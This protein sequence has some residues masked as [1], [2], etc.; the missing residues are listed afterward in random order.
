MDLDC[1]ARESD[2]A[3]LLLSLDELRALE[4]RLRQHCPAHVAAGLLTAAEVNEMLERLG[5]VI[6]RRSGLAS[7]VTSRHR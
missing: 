6:A 5:R 1:Q 2:E 3:V 7:S 4:R